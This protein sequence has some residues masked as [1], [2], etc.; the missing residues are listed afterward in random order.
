MTA[1]AWLAL[2]VALPFVLVAPGYLALRSLAGDAA[3]DLWGDGVETLGLAVVVSLAILV[4]LAFLLAET[5]GLSRWSLATAVAGLLAVEALLVRSRGSP[6]RRG[7]AGPEGGDAAS[8]P[9]TPWTGGF[10]LD[11]SLSPTSVIVVGATL[12]IVATGALLY[13]GT[14][15]YSEAAYAD[16]SEVPSTARVDP[17]QALAWTVVVENHEQRSATYALE[18]VLVSNETAGD[19]DPTRTVVDE[20]RFEVDD[21]AAGRYEVTFEAPEDGIWKVL[22]L[23]HVEGREEPLTLHRWIEAR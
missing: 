10:D 20:G 4:L 23:V 18:T 14:E 1:L 6:A 16:A 11:V 22:T 17:G 12:A 9:P 2:I 3:A 5:V 15:P 7:D 19:A 21:D 13:D 8:Q